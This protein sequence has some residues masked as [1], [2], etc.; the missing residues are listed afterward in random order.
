MIKRRGEKQKV[1]DQEMKESFKKHLKKIKSWFDEQDNIKV[2]YLKY[3]QVVED[4][5]S[6][7]E[8]ISKFLNEEFDIKA[9]TS[10]VNPDL[11]RN[12]V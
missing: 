9:M 11:Y 7:A 12:K 4:P 1:S 3:D 8:R 2:V 6:A 5:Q 10:V